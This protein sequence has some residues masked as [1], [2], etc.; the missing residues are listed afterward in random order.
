MCAVQRHTSWPQRS[1]NAASTSPGGERLGRGTDRIGQAQP[2]A[3]L[4]AVDGDLG[5]AQRLGRPSPMAGDRG[6]QV[7]VERIDIGLHLH[8]GELRRLNS[9][10]VRSGA[11]P[12]A[13]DQP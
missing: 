1:G 12:D 5:G 9:S 10:G 8:C 3:A 4:A 2:D 13:E 6:H 7:I 11:R